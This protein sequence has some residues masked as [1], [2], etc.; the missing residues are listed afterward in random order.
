MR[1]LAELGQTNDLRLFATHEAEAYPAP[2]HLKQFLQSLSD[3]GYREIAVR[4]AKGSSYGGAPML[5]FAYPVLNLPSYAAPGHGPQPALVHAPDPAGDRI[6]SLG[7]FQRGRARVDA[8]DAVGRQD[9]GAKRVACPIGRAIF[10]PTPTI[11]SS[12]A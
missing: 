4:L 12:S 5:G 11:I 3:W 7:D 1:V 8:G 2:G 9:L 6:R 10:S